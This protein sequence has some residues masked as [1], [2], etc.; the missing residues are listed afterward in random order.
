MRLRAVWQISGGAPARSYADV[1]LRYAVALIEPGDAGPWSPSRDD[2]DF[3]GVFIRRFASEI[4]DG[5]VVL[6]R[7]GTSTV[8]AI[9]LVA[10]PYE[11]IDAF[12]DVNGLDLQHARRVR[13]YALPAPHTF[14]NSLFGARPLRCSRVWNQEVVDFAER[15]V[16]SEP[17]FWQ[18]AQLPELPYED[19]PLEQL[20]EELD[21]IVARVADLVPLFQ[22]ANAFGEPPCEDELISHFVGA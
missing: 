4:A 17:T 16:N 19:P 22:D 11:Y 2:R 8:S 3:E 18:T 1:F 14:A 21:D 6:L 13:W 15:F 5:D 7:T 9:G 12:D 10:G 20:P